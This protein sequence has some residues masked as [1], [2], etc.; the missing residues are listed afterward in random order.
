MPYT[1]TA[2][3]WR[4]LDCGETFWTD[5]NQEEECPECGSS[6]LDWLDTDH[7]E[8][9]THDEMYRETKPE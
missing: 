7:K 5:D 4:C 1:E 2:H 3:K 9:Y 6:N 8:F